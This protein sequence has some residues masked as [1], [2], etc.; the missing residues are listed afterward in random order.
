MRSWIEQP[1]ISA[2][3]INKRLNAVEEL[4]RSS[5]LVGRITEQLTGVYDMER[6]MTKIVT[7]SR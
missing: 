2:A 7:W 4:T 5:I 6:L 3:L 1:L